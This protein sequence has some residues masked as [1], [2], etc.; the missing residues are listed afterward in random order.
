MSARPP[1]AFHAPSRST[2]VKDRIAH[3]HA[4]AKI[5]MPIARFVGVSYQTS[6]SNHNRTTAPS[7]WQRV[8]FIKLLHQTTTRRGMVPPDEGCLLSNFYIKPQRISVRSYGKGR[9]L[10]SNFYIKPQPI[11]L[12]LLHR[13]T[14]C[15]VVATGNGGCSLITGTKLSKK[16]EGELDRAL[17]RFNFSP[18]VDDVA[19]LLVGHG[20][21]AD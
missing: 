13:S 9:C 3:F 7:T 21:D 12:M 5:L 6:T 14:L 20:E 8:S 19:I 15:D 2:Y 18:D 11:A 4:T 16:V 17:F 1:A 10:L